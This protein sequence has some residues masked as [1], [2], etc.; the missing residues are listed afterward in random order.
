MKLGQPISLTL[1]TPRPG[2]EG[3]GAL[4]ARPGGFLS[5]T[6][7][8]S[9]SEGGVRGR[10]EGGWSILA[11]S[12]EMIYGLE[13][14]RG[15]TE[16]FQPDP[17]LWPR[18]PPNTSP[19]TLGVSRWRVFRERLKD[20]NIIFGYHLGANVPQPGVSAFPPNHD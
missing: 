8:T 10:S 18:P 2:T 3:P 15:A 4:C 20:T 5:L 12:L 9:G 17:P 7:K 6:F 13:T 14:F 19:Q 16:P 11:N 1:G